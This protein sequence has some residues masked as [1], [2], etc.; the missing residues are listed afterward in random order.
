MWIITWFVFFGLFFVNGGIGMLKTNH[1][2][3]IPLDVPKNYGTTLYTITI[4]STNGTNIEST[5]SKT[6][7]EEFVGDLK[8]IENV[9]SSDAQGEVYDFVNNTQAVLCLFGFIYALLIC[10]MYAVFT[11]KLD[12]PTVIVKRKK[13]K[14]SSKLY[15]H[16]ILSLLIP[17]LLFCFFYIFAFEYVIQ[18]T[19]CLGIES[20]D[21]PAF[22]SI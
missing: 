21:Y 11:H 4:L 19:P 2:R 13:S 6:S 16:I 12:L 15:H 20:L 14:D 9:R 17:S 10:I 7:Y 1:Y 3:K 18:M 5:Y 8:C 22:T